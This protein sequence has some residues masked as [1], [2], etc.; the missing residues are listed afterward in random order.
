MLLRALLKAKK[1]H[2]SWG[3]IL[4]KNITNTIP[5]NFSFCVTQKEMS[6][7]NDDIIFRLSELILRN[8][9]DRKQTCGPGFPR[10]PG[11]PGKPW[12]P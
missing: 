6:T 10:G 11:N 1:Q 7:V 5:Q 4:E 2:S 9:K 12:T 3:L 8:K